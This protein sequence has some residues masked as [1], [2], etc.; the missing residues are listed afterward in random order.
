[1]SARAFPPALL[2]AVGCGRDQLA[3]HFPLECHWHCYVFSPWLFG[4]RKNAKNKKKMK[5]TQ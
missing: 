2:I 4:A 3:Y 1:M 5:K